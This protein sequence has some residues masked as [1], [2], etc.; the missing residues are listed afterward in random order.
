MSQSERILIVG[1]DY[2]DLSIPAVDEALRLAAYAPSTRIVP[3][4]ALPGGPI[5][6]PLSAEALT[7]ELVERSKE[8][9]LR[10]VTMRAEAL[11]LRVPRIEPRVEF[12][13]PA[14]VLI[15]QADQLRAALIVVGTHGRQGLSHLFLGSVAEEVVRDAHCSV[16][17][18]RGEDQTVATA[19]E[20]QPALDADEEVADEE[21]DTSEEPS[22]EGAQVLSEP[23]LD[24]GQ[25]VLQVLDVPTGQVFVCTFDD[26]ETVRVEPLE[27][28]WVPQPSSAARARAARAGM[29]EARRQRD[30]MH[31][32]FAEQARRARDASE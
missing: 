15:E 8:N 28:D 17:V 23:H 2:S 9:L 5:T 6:R 16:L 14:N 31:E 32:L 13:S 26:P 29:E 7:D 4:L 10:L 19:T 30:L 3:V 12:G 11:G 27:G 24:R 22:I 25:V 1:V 21:L 18:A 20:V